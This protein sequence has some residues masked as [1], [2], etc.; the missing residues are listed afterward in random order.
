M[1]HSIT[2]DLLSPSLDTILLT[3]TFNEWVTRTNTIVDYLNPLNVYDVIPVTGSGI[4]ESRVSNYALS[5]GVVQLSLFHK[6]GE[7]G[8]SADSGNV[9][10]L[11][12]LNMSDI[13]SG[14]A[15]EDLYAVFDTDA[16]VAKKVLA[17]NSLPW[18]S[19]NFF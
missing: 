16:G 18:F 14:V 6:A 12:F 8:I 15:N 9:L 10:G 1:S 13:G 11:N 5:N 2:S 17:E 7:Q 19:L 4:T 3:D